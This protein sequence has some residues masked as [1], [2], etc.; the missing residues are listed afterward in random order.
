M[1]RSPPPTGDDLVWSPTNSQ[2]SLLGLINGAKSSL[3]VENEE[4]GD[5][6][7]VDALRSAAGRGVNVEVVMEDSSDYATEFTEL[8]GA[9]VK[10]VTYEHAK[11][12]IHAKIILADY[13]TSA[14][15]V[16]IGSEN[17]SKASLT[18]NRELG[19]ITSNASIMAGISTTLTSDFAGG[20]TYVPDA[21][22]PPQDPE[23]AGT[24]DEAP[25]A[26]T[27]SGGD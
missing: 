7:V 26:A 24:T 8:V 21:G 23:D 15:K 11:L 3:L 14:A 18:E 6:D 27:P 16:F 9:G 10:L 25:D 5:Y 19:L 12:Y 13:G 4:M 2:S 1:R 20:K 22:A 17:F